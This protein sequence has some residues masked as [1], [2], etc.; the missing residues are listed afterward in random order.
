MKERDLVLDAGGNVS[1]TLS[2]LLRWCGVNHL[3]MV[4]QDYAWINNRSHSSGHHN[5]LEDMTLQS[6][7][8]HTTDMDGN[9]I[10]T[11]VQYMTAKRE[12]EE[13]SPIT[14]GLQ[15]LRWWCGNQRYQ[16]H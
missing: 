16:G 8:Q 1:V 7:H 11:T 14:S 15:Y 2:R 13:I 9:Q 5:L 6:C 12:V 4:G 10:L 3:V